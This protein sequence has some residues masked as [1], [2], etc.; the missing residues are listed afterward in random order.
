[1]A[2]PSSTAILKTTLSDGSS[3]N[4]SAA[5][6]FSTGYHSAGLAREKAEAV[7]EK[8]RGLN[9][10]ASSNRRGKEPDGEGEQH[11]AAQGTDC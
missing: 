9:V 6:K 5:L 11:E 7:K 8:G 1:M 10:R 2:Q 4:S 3:N